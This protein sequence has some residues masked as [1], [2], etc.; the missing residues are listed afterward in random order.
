MPL[1][2]TSSAS[3]GQTPNWRAN[4]RSNSHTLMTQL[5]SRPARHSAQQKSGF[6]W[7][8]VRSSMD[9]PWGVN[10]LGIRCSRAAARPSEPA[11]AVWAHTRSGFN[12]RRAHHSWTRA[13]RSRCGLRGRTRLL[14]CNQGIP[15]WRSWS[16][17]MPGAPVITVTSWPRLRSSSESS[18]T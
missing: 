12:A 13:A 7:S 11:L 2:T 17:K 15:A 16:V 18:R 9:H 14:A 8:E 5:P 1:C 3:A 6:C 10:T 4:W